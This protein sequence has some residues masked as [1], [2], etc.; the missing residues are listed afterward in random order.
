MNYWFD[1][2][3]SLCRDG[4][5]PCA[6]RATPDEGLPTQKQS[7]GLFALIAT[8]KV[9]ISASPHPAFRSAGDFALCGARQGLLAL[10]LAT[11]LKKGGRKTFMSVL[12]KLSFDS[13][14]IFTY[15]RTSLRLFILDIFQDIP[16]SA[17]QRL[18]YRREG[19]KPDR[20]HLDVL[21]LG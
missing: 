2:I 1:W 9:G 15:T 16:Y 20:C 21:N 4:R 19:R 17:V 5:T 18:A 8:A 3:E 10:D 12:L 7:T 13:R 6:H 11:L 14:Q